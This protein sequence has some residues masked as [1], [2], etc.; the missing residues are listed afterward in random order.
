MQS[1][2][3]RLAKAQRGSTHHLVGTVKEVLFANLNLVLQKNFFACIFF[4]FHNTSF[5]FYKTYN[6][7]AN[8]PGTPLT[9]QISQ[10]SNYW[11]RPNHD[12]IF[13]RHITHPFFDIYFLDLQFT[14]SLTRNTR[15]FLPASVTPQMPTGL[16]FLLFEFFSSYI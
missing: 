1:K 13:Y 3:K 10:Y 6:F 16:D 8:I 4:F 9:P 5:Y 11:D 7:F 15:L 12:F 2:E 14:L